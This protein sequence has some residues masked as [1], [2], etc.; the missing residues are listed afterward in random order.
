MAYSRLGQWK[1]S[2]KARETTDVMRWPKYSRNVVTQ[3]I[4]SID[5]C[6]KF[7]ISLLILLIFGT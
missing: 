4:L 5:R 6:R 1:A 2:G 7:D 3:P